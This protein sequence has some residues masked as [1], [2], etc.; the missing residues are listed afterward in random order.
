MMGLEL[1][2]HGGGEVKKVWLMLGYTIAIS[3]WSTPNLFH[4]GG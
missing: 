2:G 3:A 1:D 4:Y